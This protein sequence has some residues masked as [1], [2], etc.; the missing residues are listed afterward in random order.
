MRAPAPTQW[1]ALDK[2]ACNG[3]TD[4]CKELVRL[5]AKADAKDKASCCRLRDSFVLCVLLPDRHTSCCSAAGAWSVRAAL[6]ACRV[7][8]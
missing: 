6:L 1:N 4:T 3:H 2:A 7:C 8:H 5:G